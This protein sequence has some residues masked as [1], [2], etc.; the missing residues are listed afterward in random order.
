MPVYPNGNDDD[1][2][3]P[4][5]LSEIIKRHN[6]TTSVASN[7]KSRIDKLCEFGVD[8]ECIND[9]N[10]QEFISRVAA[11]LNNYKYKSHDRQIIQQLQMFG[12]TAPQAYN[13]VSLPV[14]TTE[15]VSAIVGTDDTQ[16]S[17]EVAEM[18]VKL[19]RDNLGNLDSQTK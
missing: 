15:D 4:N 19:I 12:L 11:Y 6:S 2:L 5:E 10:K 17:N 16:I 18:V 3:T 13:A 1:S 7:I 14:L 9:N 8:L